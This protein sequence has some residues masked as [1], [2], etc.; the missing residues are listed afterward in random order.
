M[1][2]VYKDDRNPE[3]PV[4][5]WMPCMREQERWA[6]LNAID[7][8]FAAIQDFD[9]ADCINNFCSSPN[10]TYSVAQAEQLITLG[11]FCAHACQHEIIEAI[12]W[13]MEHMTP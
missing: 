8:R 5:I 6:T 4:V 12:A 9:L 3:T 2:T 10:F 1:V 13:K 7:Q 11:Q